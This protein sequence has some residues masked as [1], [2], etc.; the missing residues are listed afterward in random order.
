MEDYTKIK[1]DDICEG[2]LFKYAQMNPVEIIGLTTR[3][4][5]F[6]SLSFKGTDIESMVELCLRKIVWS[7]DD[8]KTWTPIID[9]EGNAKLPELDKNPQI[10]L[11]LFYRF[12][13]DVLTPVFIESKTFQNS[14]SR[15][16]KEVQ[17]DK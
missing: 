15:N 7:K 8:G 4:V 14:M 12:R 2:V 17:E 1:Y 6:S 5:S 10:G 16:E 9:A 13:K 11:D 3:N